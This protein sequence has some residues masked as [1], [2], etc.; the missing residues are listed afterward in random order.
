MKKLTFFRFKGFWKDDKQHGHGVEEWPDGAKYVGEYF[1]GAKNGKGI[2][3]FPDGS[4]YEV[5]SKNYYLN[6]ILTP[7]R[8]SSR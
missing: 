6:S 3:N 5:N 1:E 7:N 8:V 2:L 4:S